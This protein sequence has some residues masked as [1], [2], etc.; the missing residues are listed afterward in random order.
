MDPTHFLSRQTLHRPMGE[1]PRQVEIE[2]FYDEH[3]V[4][5]LVAFSRWRTRLNA[6]W[7]RLTQRERRPTDFAAEPSRG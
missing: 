1:R 6:A 7:L 4:E 5:A 3:G 2:R